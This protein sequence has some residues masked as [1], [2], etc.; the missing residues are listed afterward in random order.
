[1]HKIRISNTADCPLTTAPALILREGRIIAQGMMTYTAIGAACDLELTT[2][3]DISVK[4]LDEETGRI[5]NAE[6]WNNNS[7]SRSN[8]T[9]TISLTNRRT[10]TIELEVRRSVLGNIDDANDGGKITQV[11][12]H[13]GEWMTTDS[14]PFWWN[15][16]SWPYWWYHF[17]TVGQV[18]WDIKLKPGESISLEYKWHYFWL[19]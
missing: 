16:Y 17:N 4:K 10:D 3:I 11:G 19:S 5:P 8:M 7:Y 18:N 6:R 1:M 2:A 9:G 15:W 12:R 13:E 14:F